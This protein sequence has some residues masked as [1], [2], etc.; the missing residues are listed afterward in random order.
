MNRTGTTCS[1]TNLHSLKRV[2]RHPYRRLRL[3]GGFE[4][5]TPFVAF[6]T[7]L[8]TTLTFTARGGD[9]AAPAPCML[10]GFATLVAPL[11]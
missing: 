2:N 4:A 11:R 1:C 5:L 8:L 7:L 3:G 10:F 9:L 6:V